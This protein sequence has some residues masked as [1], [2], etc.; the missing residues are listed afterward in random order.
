MKHIN[1]LIVLM[2]FTAVAACGGRGTETGTPKPIQTINV[3][4]QTADGNDYQV[5]VDEN[6]QGTVEAL[7]KDGNVLATADIDIDPDENGDFEETVTF[8]DGSELTIKGHLEGNELIIEQS[9]I[10]E[11]SDV[12]IEEDDSESGEETAINFGKN[13][14]STETDEGSEKRESEREKTSE[15]SSDRNCIMGAAGLICW[16]KIHR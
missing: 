8:D 15:D 4:I 14:T 16:S 3:Q 9:K 1:I 11:K 5:K 12:K 7:D 2:L 6:W 13:D 10:V